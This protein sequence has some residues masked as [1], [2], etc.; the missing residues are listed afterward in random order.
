LFV[1]DTEKPKD[2]ATYLISWTNKM[3]FADCSLFMMKEN[4]QKALVICY[5]SIGINTF[6]VFV[7][8]I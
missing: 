7:I 8:D 1:I 2:E 6:N 3:D 5:K 4:G